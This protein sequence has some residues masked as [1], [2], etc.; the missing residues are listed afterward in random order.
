MIMRA[1][2]W[3]ARRL[4]GAGWTR[5]V[6][7]LTSTGAR[8]GLPRSTVLAVHEEPGGSLLVVGSN[9]G[10]DKHPDWSANLLKNP[11]AQVRF[12]GDRFPVAAELLSGEER[13][14]VWPA[15]KAGNK[16]YEK[17]E[18][19]VE[20]EMRVFRLTRASMEA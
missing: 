16:V 17:Y 10:K 18:P 3:V 20:R 19:Q 5:R 2:D 13:A 7:E 6:A 14:A 15:L 9:F 11:S 4:I 1:M 8:S 12:A